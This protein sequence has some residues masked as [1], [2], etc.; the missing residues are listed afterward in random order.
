MESDE[1]SENENKNEND[2][3]ALDTTEGSSAFSSSSKYVR[4]EGVPSKDKNIE[5]SS[6]NP[7]K[8]KKGKKTKRIEKELEIERKEKLEVSFFQIKLN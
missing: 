2:S 8:D 6:S 5:T 3:S 1:S 4:T 7:K